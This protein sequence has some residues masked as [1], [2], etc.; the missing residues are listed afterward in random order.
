MNKNINNLSKQISELRDREF[1]LEEELEKVRL[2]LENAREE[3]VK[4]EMASIDLSNSVDVHLLCYGK[5]EIVPHSAKIVGDLAI[6]QHDGEWQICS[7]FKGKRVCYCQSLEIALE[8][9]EVLQ[10]FDWSFAQ[11]EDL[12][13]KEIRDFVLAW[14]NR[15]EAIA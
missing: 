2:Q 13:P 12:A 11:T 6:I 10:Q 7:V 3:F 8:L 15:R 5:L 4:A 9:I 14:E 1:D